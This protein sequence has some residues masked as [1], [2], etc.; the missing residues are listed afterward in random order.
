MKLRD[1]SG[2]IREKKRRSWHMITAVKRDFVLTVLLT[3]PKI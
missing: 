3:L 1:R 2:G